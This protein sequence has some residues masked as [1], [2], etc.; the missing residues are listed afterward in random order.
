MRRLGWSIDRLKTRFGD[1]CLGQFRAR[2]PPQFTRAG[3]RTAHGQ[4]P[5]Q[6]AGNAAE[7]GFWVR[8]I[9][10]SPPEGV[11]DVAT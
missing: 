3:S 2:N 10:N 4:T 11:V 5:P 9:S 7:G 8:A 6:P 1:R